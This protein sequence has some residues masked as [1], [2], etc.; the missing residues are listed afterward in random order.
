MYIK[1]INKF[2]GDS[3]SIGMTFTLIDKVVEE[4][5]WRSINKLL[6]GIQEYPLILHDSLR[7]NRIAYKNKKH[8][9]HPFLGI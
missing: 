1:K 9:Y 7:R 4:H 6:K 2:Q 3:T 5:T 8:T